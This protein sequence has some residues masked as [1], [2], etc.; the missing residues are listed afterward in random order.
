MEFVTS[1]HCRRV[2]VDGFKTGTEPL[3]PRS[4]VA[5]VGDVSDLFQTVS[6]LFGPC[7][8][9]DTVA[10]KE[11]NNSTSSG[12]SSSSSSSCSSSSNGSGSGSGSSSCSGSGSGSSS[13]NCSCHCNS[14]S[15]SRSSDSCSSNDGFS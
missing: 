3:V 8:T 1:Q 13:W 15:S 7:A 11:P 9:L 6:G 5:S 4:Y 2:A 10:S 14:S 12:S